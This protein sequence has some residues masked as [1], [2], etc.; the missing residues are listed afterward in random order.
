MAKSLAALA[1][2]WSVLDVPLGDVAVDQR[3]IVAVHAITHEV[4]NDALVLGQVIALAWIPRVVE[5]GRRVSQR[6]GVATDPAN[7]Y[8]EK[9]EG[10]GGGEQVRTAVANGQ[11]LVRVGEP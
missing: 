7:G 4:Q 1:A 9:V 10:R 2:A 6:Y 8:R 3:Q 11:A 5:H